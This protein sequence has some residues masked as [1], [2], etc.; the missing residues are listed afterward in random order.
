MN[1]NFNKS[2]PQGFVYKGNRFVFLFICSIVL[3]FSILVSLRLGS[4]DIPFDDIF[5]LL[6]NSS[7]REQMPT[8]YVIITQLRLPRI[9]AAILCGAAL[10]VSGAAFQSM[11]INPLVSPDLLGVLA[12]AAFG[13]ALGILAGDSFFFV[14]VGSVLFGLIAVLAALTIAGLF[15][16]NR[17]IMLIIGGVVSSSLFSSL[18]TIVKFTADTNNKL[19]AIV[20]W[21]MGGFSAVT[22]N[23]IKYIGPVILAGIIGIILFSKH[24]NFLALGDD[25]AQS[26]GIRTTRT[27]YFIIFMATLICAFTVTLGGIVGWIG[28]M[29][30][31]IARMLTGPDNKKLI[32]VAAFTGAIYL[33]LIDNICRT[34]FESELP[35]GIM[36]SLI[37]VPFF[38]FILAKTGKRWS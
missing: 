13:S 30:P 1:S 10:S 20:Y 4:S 22:I 16:G 19:P 18:L 14:Q 27:R 6:I 5:K 3:A 23:D 31:H 32:P 11:F 36:T 15:P 29:I 24:L 25:E 35:I 34:A 37:G 33:L 12:G 21:L 38:I 7:Y 26:M 9:I 2:L 8:E 17:L 28:L